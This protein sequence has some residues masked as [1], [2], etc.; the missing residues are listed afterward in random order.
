MSKR[1]GIIGLGWLGEPVAKY[2]QEKGY[3]VKGSTTCPEKA[4]RLQREGIAA[5][6]LVFQPNPQGNP[7]SIMKDIDLLMV[8]LPPGTRKNPA[9]YHLSQIQSIKSLANKANIQKILFIS[10]TSVYP[11]QYQDAKESDHLDLDRTGNPV[12]L[13]AENLLRADRNYALAVIRFGGLV[14]YDRVPGRHAAHLQNVVGHSPVNYIHRDDA[15]RLVHWVLCRQ[16][17]DQTFNG[18]SPLHPSRKEIYGRNAA[19]VKFHPPLGYDSTASRP[20]KTVST[21]KILLTGFQYLFPDPREFPYDI[22]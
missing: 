15:V 8:N 19:T 2:L 12:L 13:Q 4:E 18:V 9:A 7:A 21:E 10:S 1:I 11:D 22:P 6:P 17:W 14:G 16:L 5:F 20:W 3:Q